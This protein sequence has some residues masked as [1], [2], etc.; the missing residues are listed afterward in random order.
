MIPRYPHGY[1]S[2]NINHEDL[3]KHFSYGIK[4]HPKALKT[5]YSKEKKHFHL[6]RN[7][8]SRPDSVTDESLTK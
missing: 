8:N 2:T 6:I 1:K 3:A 7:L 4:H 5:I